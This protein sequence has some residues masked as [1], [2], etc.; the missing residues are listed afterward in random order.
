V[1]TSSLGHRG[2]ASISIIRVSLRIHEYCVDGNH[3]MKIVD[4]T[5]RRSGCF[6]CRRRKRRCDERKPTCLRCAKAEDSCT[7]PDPRCSSNIRLIISRGTPEVLLPLTHSGEVDFINL[8]S[9][10]VPKLCA[11]YPVTA[12]KLPTL[13]AGLWTPPTPRYL[14]SSPVVL[15]GLSYEESEAELIQYC[16]FSPKPS[17][18]IS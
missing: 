11:Q 5:R 4:G 2:L 14:S 10:D 8:A 1:S 16:G 17:C 13:S 18:S 15:R 9:D 3:R 6:G 7:Y 12:T